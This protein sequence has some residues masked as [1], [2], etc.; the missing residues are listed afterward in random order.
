MSDRTAHPTGHEWLN[1]LFTVER[2][3][4]RSTK[5]D[6]LWHAASDTVDGRLYEVRLDVRAN[7]WTCNCPA[8]RPCKHIRRCDHS[9]RVSWW[10]HSLEGYQ[11][12]N[13]VALRQAYQAR[14]DADEDTRDDHD[15]LQA[16]TLLLS[17]RSLQRP[18]A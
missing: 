6:E 9:R 7:R 3:A 12:P 15:A 18:A 13:L 1:E 16:V 5:W 14:I 17:G 2:D 8:T 10:M 11:A 4:A